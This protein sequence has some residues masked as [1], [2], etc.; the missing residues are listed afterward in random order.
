MNEEIDLLKY[1]LTNI[2]IQRD[3]L[4]KILRK[5]KIKD[6]VYELI[7]HEIFEYKKF[8]ISLNRMLETRQ[9]KYNKEANVLLGVASSINANINKMERNEDYLKMLEENAK[10]NIL[11]IN[12]IKK[13]YNIKSK[14]VQKLITRLVEFEKNNLLE[15]D[16][17][18]NI[19]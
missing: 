2:R 18:I 6:E 13:E 17:I 3:M 11:D 15:I 19:Q 5:K 4:Q 7:R 14:T 10:V 1:I 12:R 16:S 8:I 9:K